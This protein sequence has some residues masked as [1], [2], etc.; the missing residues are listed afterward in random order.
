[1]AL[2]CG[3]GDFSTIAYA[4]PFA[5]L[6]GIVA[7]RAKTRPSPV[8][9]LMPELLSL[10]LPDGSVREVP[11]GTLPKDVVAQI[12]ARLAKDAIAVELEGEVQDLVT[13][14]RKSGAFRVL[15]A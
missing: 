12:G 10:T 15:T 5:K 7:G 1:M 8:S 3:V 13:P 9:K 4:Q 6:L 14:L 2:T 11:S